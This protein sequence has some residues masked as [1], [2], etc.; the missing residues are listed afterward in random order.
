MPRLPLATWT[1]E[2]W[3][4]VSTAVGLMAGGWLCVLANI[5]YVFGRR[6]DPSW[7]LLFRSDRAA[8]KKKTRSDIL[9]H[10]LAVPLRVS[11]WKGK[12][13]S[14]GS[15]TAIGSLLGSSFGMILGSLHL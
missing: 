10:H 9:R 3:L 4:T 8:G 7:D 5:I 11:A 1:L 15:W 14:I 6:A 2:S 13:L 12:Y